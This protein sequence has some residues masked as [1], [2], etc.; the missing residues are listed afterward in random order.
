MISVEAKCNKCG[1]VVI[2]DIKPQLELELVDNEADL[3]W[4]EAKCNKCGEMQ[5]FKVIIE[6]VNNNVDY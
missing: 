1:E 2:F 5:E 3:D 4:C 6:L